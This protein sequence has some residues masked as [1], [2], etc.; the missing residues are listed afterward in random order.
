MGDRCTGHCCKAFTLPCSMDV[1]KLKV[2]EGTVTDGAIIADML[3]PMYAGPYAGMPDDI[4]AKVDKVAA[5]NRTDEPAFVYTCRHFDGAN[6]TNY[7]G[8]PDMCKAYPYGTRCEY[9]GCEWKA[10]R[11]GQTETINGCAVERPR[12]RPGHFPL[13]DEPLDQLMSRKESGPC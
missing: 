2:E 8:R 12:K 10:A 6:C 3:I 1:V 7:E 4:R 13:S 9:R 5:S 11:D